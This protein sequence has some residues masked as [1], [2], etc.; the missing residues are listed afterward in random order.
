MMIPSIKLLVGIILLAGIGPFILFLAAGDLDWTRGWIFAVFTFVYTIYSRSAVLLKNPDLI[1]ERT[2]SLKK[3]NV[4][5]WD[6]VLVPLI[7]VFMPTTVVIVAGLDH[8]FR[9]SP[10]LPPWLPVAALVTMA[11]GGLLAQWAVMTNRFF[12]AVVRI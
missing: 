9:W 3:D 10:Q 2:G 12:S 1:S 5:P 4:E 7:G 8:R 6:R 11:L